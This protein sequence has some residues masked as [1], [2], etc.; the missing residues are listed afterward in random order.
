MKVSIVIP[1]HNEQD[2]L[3]RCLS[4]INDQSIPDDVIIEVIVVLNRCSDGTED[5]AKE[6]G[7][8]VVENDSKNISAI[9]N[10]GVEFATGEWIVTIDAD[11]WMSPGVMSEIFWRTK[12]ENILG[13]GIQIRPER[14]SVGIATGYAMMLVP[15]FFLRLS[16]GL[17]WFRK[18]D[19]MA[20]GGFDETKHIAEDIDFLRRL[21]KHGRLTGNRYEKITSEFVTTSCRKFDQFGDWHFVRLFGNPFKAYNAMNG[22]NQEYLDKN[23]YEVKRKKF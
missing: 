5:V 8:V 20:I 2:Y 12:T 6:Y 11:S 9:R 3:G 14:M 15:A 21:K 18:S 22:E 19:F 1:A 16:F 23:W 4:S 17:Y 7:A 13:G 10:T